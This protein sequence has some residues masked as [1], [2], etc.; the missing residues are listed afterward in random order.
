MSE[1]PFDAL[2]YAPGN[3]LH[4]VELRGELI[5][6]GEPCDKWC[7]RERRILASVDAEKLL[8]DFAR[9][10]ALSVIHLWLCPAVVRNFLATG[11][12]TLRDAAR[13]AA[14]KEFLKTVLLIL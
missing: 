1:H 5:T 6:H 2:Q 10:N 3:L 11:A 14:R 7:G 4:R 12:E 8:F 9:W 13:D